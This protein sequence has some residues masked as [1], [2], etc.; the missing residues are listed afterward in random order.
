MHFIAF[1]PFKHFDEIWSGQKDVSF[2]FEFSPLN[3]LNRVNII[4]RMV[5]LSHI[6]LAFALI[7]NIIKY[8]FE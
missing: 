3:E 4:F 2:I 8:V 6:Y 7:L 1:T 5:M